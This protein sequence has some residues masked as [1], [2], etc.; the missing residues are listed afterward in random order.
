MCG[1][2]Y[3]VQ[4]RAAA[5][6][7]ESDPGLRP[8]LLSEQPAG[9]DTAIAQPSGAAWTG[10]V[11]A[12]SGTNTTNG[13][14]MHRIHSDYKADEYR[15]SMEVDPMDELLTREEVA[16]ILKLK[17]RTVSHA[18]TG[19]PLRRQAGK[20]VA[21]TRDG[22]LQAGERVQLRPGLMTTRPAQRRL[23]ACCCAMRY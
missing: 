23:G 5:L 7:V 13:Y 2:V 8:H 17:P 6:S 11:A 4:G 3:G 22:C 19:R 16:A 18:P 21:D 12:P 10:T 15:M 1:G 9:Q 20:S 14:A